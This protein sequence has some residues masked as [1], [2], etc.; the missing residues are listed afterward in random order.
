MEGQEQTRHPM[1]GYWRGRIFRICLKLAGMTFVAEVVY[2]LAGILGL[3]DIGN[4]QIFVVRYVLL[5]TVIDFGGI[6]IA[7]AALNSK[8]FSA[9]EKNR[10][11]C[12]LAFLLTAVIECTHYSYAETTLLPCIVILFAALVVD[13]NLC[14]NICIISYGTLT[15]AS[16]ERYMEGITVGFRVL[17]SFIIVAVAIFCSYRVAILLAQHESTQFWLIS[18][19]RKKKVELMEQIRIEPTTGLLSRRILM[20]TLEQCC[21]MAKNHSEP[22]YL[23]MVDIDNFKKINDT[24]GHVCGDEVLRKIGRIIRENVKGTAEGY[25]YGGEEFVILFRQKDMEDVVRVMERIRVAMAKSRF[26]F[27]GQDKITI[28]CGIAEYRYGMK[29][30]EWICRADHSLYQAKHEG[31]NRVIVN[32]E[33]AG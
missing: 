10:I 13:V 23:A 32:L 16:A 33:Q 3:T 6:I 27:L 18:R 12:Y 25:R 20:D 26:D 14:R 28:S 2:F 4:F 30:A 11:V 21:R 15:I 17:V 7:K 9:R 19:S 22:M 31:K 5:P 1:D 8:R 24:Y 29:P